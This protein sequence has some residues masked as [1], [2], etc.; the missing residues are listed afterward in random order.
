MNDIRK[1]IHIDMDAFYASVE[2]LDNPELSGK[3]IAV[4]GTRERGV[5]A[6]AS[7]EARK[8]GVKSAMNSQTAVKL[9]PDLI[10]VKPNFSRYKEVSK[11]IHEIFHRYTDI[12]E[13]LA[14]DEAYLDVTEN[15]QK[16]PSATFIAQSVK[17]DIQSEIGLI[18]S[19]GVSYNK[20]LAKLA[21]DQDKPN[22]LFVITPEDS[23]KYIDELQIERFHG[24][25]KV[26]ADRMHELQI[27]KGKD[28]KGF[29]LE[30]LN[31]YFGKMGNF[32]FEISR[33]IDNRSVVHDRERKSIAAENTFE[34]DIFDSTTFYKEAE[35]ILQTLWIRYERFNKIGKTLTLKI[36][37]KD[38]TVKN[39]SRTIPEG[40][41]NREM[42]K[43]VSEELIA[44]FVPL[45]NPVR[46]IGFQISGFRDLEIS[47]LKLEI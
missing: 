9:C 40:I 8:F 38:F 42:I 29:T 36:K 11:Q 10:F 3:P 2:Q 1:I 5:I 33:G 23:Q 30:Q 35:S 6:A 46:L 25:G 32:L 31:Q 17:T 37:T 26:T 19:A 43:K 20:F 22:G 44:Q 14:L 45:E 15:K 13:P 21:S 28:L 16:M 24:I 27:Y 12:I 34:H 4:G 18:A 47:Q 41:T 39:R 7:Y